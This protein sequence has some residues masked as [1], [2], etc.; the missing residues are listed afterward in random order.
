MKLKKKGKIMATRTVRPS[1]GL[2]L[3]PHAPDPSRIFTP[4]DVAAKSAEIQSWLVK[5]KGADFN[6]SAQSFLS[7]REDSDN[8]KASIQEVDALGLPHGEG[9]TSHNHWWIAATGD[10]TLADSRGD[11]IT[12]PDPDEAVGIEVVEGEPPTVI[13]EYSYPA[14]CETR[15]PKNANLRQLGPNEED[16]AYVRA[17]YFFDWTG[18]R[19]HPDEWRARQD[20][21]DRDNLKPIGMS[22]RFWKHGWKTGVAGFDLNDPFGQSAEYRKMYIGLEV[23]T[24]VKQQIDLSTGGGRPSGFGVRSAAALSVAQVAAIRADTRQESVIAAEYGLSE[25]DVAEIRRAPLPVT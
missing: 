23:E 1:R 11:G 9:P 18:Q 2:V 12:E 4:A 7:R 21:A 15:Y 6:A 22:A 8:E 13:P 16:K 20:L 24:W 5:T 14:D 3:K 19:V 17:G 25:A 10:G